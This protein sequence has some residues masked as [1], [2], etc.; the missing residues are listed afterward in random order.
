MGITLVHLKRS[1]WYFYLWQSIYR[2]YKYGL[3]VVFLSI[4]ISYQTRSQESVHTIRLNTD[5]LLEFYRARK[6]T[7]GIVPTTDESIV[8]SKCGFWI[9]AQLLDRWNELTPEL[10]VEFSRLMQ[11]D[12]ME[13][14]TVVGYFHIFYDTSEINEPA[15]L[16]NNNLR[17]PGT[18]KA[19]IDSVAKIFNHVWDVEINQMGYNAPPFEVGQSYYNV[20]IKEMAPYYGYT[21]PIEPPINGSEIPP[22]YC[23]YI[24]IDNDYKEFPS[25]GI[26]GL[27]VTAAHEFHHAIQIGSYGYWTDDLF[28]YELT[29]TWFEDVVYTEVNDYYNWVPRYFSQ[30][31][32]GQ[33]LNY[34]E[35][36]D[37]GERCIWAH[38]LT[39]RF[40]SN[41]M[42]EIWA[43]M[44]TQPFLESTNNILIK[45]GTSLQSEFALFTYWNYFTWDR[46]DTIKYYPEG[47]HY[48]RF[49]PLKSTTFLG[50]TS[51]V[52]GDVFPLSSS[53]YEFQLSTDTITA[54][55]A[56]VDV[57][58]A[59]R[60]EN[61]DT[62]C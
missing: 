24:E 45:K 53:M 54:I 55:V 41:I 49:L 43:G 14:D 60:K 29:S 3:I 22:R 6:N 36:P 37:Y 10:R 51:T 39:K 5:R 50:S 57:E 56:N 34:Y 48:P 47:N 30:F 12:I 21:W 7:Y 16:D 38:F 42:S 35:Y 23:S 46:A 27:E 52:R 4:P 11:A 40:G 2:W 44:R 15:L 19:Y 58:A 9:Q 28:A 31:S 33:S 18:V 59:L 1:Y 61:T 26:N 13:C 20:Y 25:K 8:D 32:K 62:E 17:I